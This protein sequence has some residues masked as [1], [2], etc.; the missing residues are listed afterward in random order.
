MKREHGLVLALVVA[1]VFL[2]ATIPLF[3]Q[4]KQNQTDPVLP[5][6]V[7]APQLIAWSQL[8]SPQQLQQTVAQQEKPVLQTFA[9]MIMRDGST[10]I[11]K[12]STNTAYSLGEQQKAKP[13]EGKQ[14]RISGILDGSDE[15]L[16]ILSI[17]PVS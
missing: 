5:A 12:T 7:L 14:V 8:Q 1:L 16:H 10:Y 9:G 3:A 15:S 11:L 6:V 17:E 4:N 2:S 13:Y